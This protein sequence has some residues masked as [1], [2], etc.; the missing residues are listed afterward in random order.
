MARSEGDDQRLVPRDFVKPFAEAVRVGDVLYLSG[1]IGLDYEAGRLAPGGIAAETAQALR[2]ITSTL[3]KFGL[4]MDAVFK[5]TVML[6]DMDEWA[7]FNAAYLPF[8]RKDRLPA[9]SAF[10]TSGLAF[11]ARVEIECLARFD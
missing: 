1:E 11:G 7:A 4:T 6:A 3:A 8:F 5:C 9:R 2:N 10:G